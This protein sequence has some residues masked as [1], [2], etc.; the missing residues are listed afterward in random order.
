[1][2]KLSKAQAELLAAIEAGVVCY[3]AHPVRR[4]NYWYR[5]DTHK[6]CTRTAEALIA[7]GLVRVSPVGDGRLRMDA[8]PK[9]PVQ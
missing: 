6:T 9:E 5:T 3:Y 2:T 8:K 4:G 1:M 7:R